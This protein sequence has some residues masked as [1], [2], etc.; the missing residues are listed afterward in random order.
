MKI[1]P[2]S[3]RPFFKELL[4][5]QL[6]AL[7]EV[8]RWK[9][10]AAAATELELATPSVWQQVR[11]LE[12]EFGV[13]LLRVDGKNVEFTEDGK[14]LV[15]A[16]RQIVEGF[17]SLH[18][19]FAQRTRS[20]PQRLVLAST[21]QLLKHELSKSLAE[22]RRRHPELQLSIIDRSSQGARASLENGEADIAIVGQFDA[23]PRAAITVTP[24]T[25]YSF[26]LMAPTGH[27]LLTAP[28][29]TIKKIAQQPLVVPSAAANCRSKLDELF[30]N[31]GVLHALNIVVDA[32][33]FDLLVD[34]VIGGFG[35]CVMS[36]SPAVMFATRH[37]LPRHDAP[38]R[39][40]N[41]RLAS[42]HRPPRAL[43]R[44]ADTFLNHRKS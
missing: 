16:A 23:E 21:I 31:A 2:T 6:R 42:T 17:D 5:Q 44:V 36:V 8:S 11:G 37:R 32:S 10:F 34:N 19:M 18:D 26:M 14:A 43:R 9:S 35:I 30:R 1:S 39:R 24:L 13:E 20:V 29:V 33:N 12:A 25:A 7:V 4:F 38:V 27:P 28:R 40:R 3:P 22:F 41:H 15:D